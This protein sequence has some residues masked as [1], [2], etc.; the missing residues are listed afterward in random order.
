MIIVSFLCGASASGH[1]SKNL[2]LADDAKRAMI[3]LSSIC[4][5]LAKKLHHLL[6]YEVRGHCFE[7]SAPTR[8]DGQ[9][10]ALS[11]SKI[12]RFIL[13]IF[14]IA[15]AIWTLVNCVLIAARPLAASAASGTMPLLLQTA[16]KP[17]FCGLP[18]AAGAP[19]LSTTVALGLLAFNTPY[20][21]GGRAQ[22]TGLT[23]GACHGTEG[24]SGAAAHLVF[25]QPVPDLALAAA[26]G[27][28]VAGFAGHAVPGEFDGPPP[29]VEILAGLAALAGAM[30][31]KDRATTPACTVTA[32]SLIGIEL[33][34]IQRA[35]ASADADRLD[36]LIDSTR[37][38]LGAMAA[39]MPDPAPILQTNQALR[40][41]ADAVD[42][43][44][45]AQA[46]QGIRTAS[47]VWEAIMAAH[48]ERKFILTAENGTGP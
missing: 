37:F 42:D 29:A 34:L 22:R 48:R 33:R 12:H 13:R 2:W 6:N 11:K 14:G 45:R 28:N 24:P 21:F 40:A 41:A 27:V 46:M 9:E 39:G 16:L 5:R 38:V 47:E 26:R 8:L 44:K 3:D 23:C 10:W 25:R 4:N 36:F 1:I 17:A 19:A 7:E 18:G 20:L 31:P 15:P 35:M 43:G 30:A 32:D